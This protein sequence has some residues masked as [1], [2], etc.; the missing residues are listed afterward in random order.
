MSSRR[1]HTFML[2][3]FL[4][5]RDLTSVITIFIKLRENQGPE[6]V[7]G[8]IQVSCGVCT[9]WFLVVYRPYRVSH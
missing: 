2:L 1:N 6:D 3:A 4:G 9:V 7:N 5:L 8:L